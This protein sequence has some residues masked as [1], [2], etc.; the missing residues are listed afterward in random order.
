MQSKIGEATHIS[1]WSIVNS[2]SGDSFLREI[3]LLGGCS[4]FTIDYS[5]LTLLL[6]KRVKCYSFVFFKIK[7]AWQENEALTVYL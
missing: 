6:F 7:T 4:S 1:E 3:S 5:P 2:E